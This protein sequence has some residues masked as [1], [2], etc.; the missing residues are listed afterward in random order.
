[1]PAPVKVHKEYVDLI[2]L[3]ESRGMHI[4]DK[5]HAIKKITQVGYYRLSG[6]WYPCRL[7]EVSA[8]KIIGRIDT[9]RKGTSFRDVYDLY[10]FDKKLRLHVMNA[11]ERIEIFVRSVIAH[12]IGKY[13]PLAYLDDNFINPKHLNPHPSKPDQPSPRQA[14]LTKHSC[15]IS[16][17]REDSIKWHTSRYE[18]IPFWVAIEVW[19]FGLMS[20]YYGMLKDQ[21]RNE[22]LARLGIASG[23]GAIFQNWLSAMNVL[24]NRCAHHSRI[25]NKLNEPKLKPLP[26]DPYFNSLG[27]G[28]DQYERMFGMI[29]VLWFLVKKIGPGSNWLNNVADLVDSKP[30]V[31]GCHLTAMGFPNNDGFPRKAFGI[32]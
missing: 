4:S 31:P 19:D 29:A 25:W 5:H 13:H 3:L 17:S 8:G 22:I 15:E 2:E 10:L 21:Y 32:Q 1:M 20:K 28:H 12:E 27:L 14:W 18:G 6:F 7:P 30:L 23:N 24:R 26:N 9:V 16:K 11:L